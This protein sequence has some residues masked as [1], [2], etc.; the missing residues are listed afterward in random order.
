MLTATY[1]LVVI[2][3]EQNSMRR[4]LHQLQQNIR[5]GWS[6]LHTSDSDRIETTFNTL[7]QF[8]DYCRARK[9]EQYLIPALRRATN[10][11]D[12]LLAELDALSV[13]GLRLLR[14]IGDQLRHAIDAGN[15]CISEICNSMELY[16]RKLLDRLAKEEAELFPIA[17]QVFSV[18]EWFTIAEKFLSVDGQ[19]HGSRSSPHLPPLLESIPGQHFVPMNAMQSPFSRRM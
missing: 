7:T 3:N 2:A 10:E 1:S 11:A 14:K 5:N 6:E 8:D 18:E 12:D 15:V 13:M 19:T 9:V 17:Q 4:M 16:C